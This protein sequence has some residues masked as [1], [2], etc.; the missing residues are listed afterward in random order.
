MMK[1]I[2]VAILLATVSSL[3]AIAHSEDIPLVNLLT[4]ELAIKIGV[5]D[6]KPVFYHFDTGSTDF[7][8]W[9]G[10]NPPAGGQPWFPWGSD[11]KLGAAVLAAYASN[12]TGYS[13]APS[14]ANSIQFYDKSDSKILDYRPA[15]PESVGAIIADQGMDADYQS[16]TDPAAED[17]WK[18]EHQKALDFANNNLEG[19]DKAAALVD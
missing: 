14:S 11:Q 17:N 3:P 7:N 16:L 15:Q 12:H 10:P 8:I 4:G 5:N 18:I 1:K 2:K 6:A 13:V 19:D 9:V